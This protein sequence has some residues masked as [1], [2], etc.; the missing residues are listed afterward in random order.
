MKREHSGYLRLRS[1][2]LLYIYIYIYTRYRAKTITD[3]DYADDIALLANAPAKAE[4]LL[5]S[6]QQA[7]A[8]I[9]LHV[10]TQKT[11][12]IW[13]NQTGDI[14]TLNG[15]SLKPVDKFTYLES[16]VRSTE[17]DIDTWLAKAWTAVDRLLVIWKSNLTDKM[18]RSF[19]SSSDRVHTAI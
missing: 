18:K 1:P 7:A 16:S 11:E 4:T 9:D 2:T 6:L 14:S 3:A 8:G 13:F 17:T 19:F 5:H 12:Y 10:N 15:S